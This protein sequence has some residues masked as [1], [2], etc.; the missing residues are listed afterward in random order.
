MVVRD[1]QSIVASYFQGPDK[2]TSVR[3]ASR[4]LIFYAFAAPGI[5]PDVLSI[6]LSNACTIFDGTCKTSEY[7]VYAL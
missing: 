7:R 2:R 6:A 5:A 4:N 3:P 1:S